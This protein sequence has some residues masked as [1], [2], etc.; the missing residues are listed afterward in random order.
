MYGNIGTPERL[1]F[2][3]IGRAAN[4]AARIEAKCRELDRQ[5]LASGAF[6]ALTEAAWESH[7]TM[8]LRNI[9]EAMEIFSL[10]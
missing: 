2:S 8:E 6:A 9:G 5:I 10:R 7:G 4:E 1:E 3:V